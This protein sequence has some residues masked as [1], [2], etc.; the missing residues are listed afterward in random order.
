MMRLRSL[1]LNRFGAFSG[2]TIDFGPAPESGPDFHIIHGPNEAGKTTT[3]EGWLR[4]LYGFDHR[5][6]Y[7]FFHQRKN[8]EVSGTLESRGR[9]W[10]LRRLPTQKASL[11]D[12]NG[13]AV[14]ETVL[15]AALGGLGQD[16]YR[17][18]LCLDDATIER[19]G[20]EIVASG[21]R[22]RRRRRTRPAAP[23]PPCGSMPRA[24]PP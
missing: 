24:S 21:W 17:K 9:E 14:P 12:P 8:L 2:R 23:W 5:E 18:L 22:P 1:T 13:A 6:P 15:S 7:G 20:E 10:V 3:M 19:G 11:L 4:L 16:D